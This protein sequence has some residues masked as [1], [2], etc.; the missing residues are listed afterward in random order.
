MERLESMKPE[1]LNRAFVKVSEDYEKY[2][3]SNAKVK[4]VQYVAFTG[5]SRL[6]LLNYM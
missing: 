4:R 3:I 2:V 5:R 6:L 1:D